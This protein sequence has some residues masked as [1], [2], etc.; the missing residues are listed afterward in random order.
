MPG[1]VP[2]IH[3][4]RRHDG[5][6]ISTRF[7]APAGVLSWTQVARP[8]VDGR[9]KSGH[10][11]SLLFSKPTLASL[12]LSYR[13]C[14]KAGMTL[15]NERGCFRL[16][17][18]LFATPRQSNPQVCFHRLRPSLDLQPVP[19]EQRDREPIHSKRN[20][21]RVGGFAIG[22]LKAPG[23]SEMIAMAVKTHASR[24]LFG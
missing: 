15:G 13:L 4:V 10:D 9:N 14:T 12:S 24:R 5:I 21:S 3:A 2:G 20:A 17:E 16:I 11:G 7:S 18:T 1:L 19:R 8:G 22:G 6:R 23:Q